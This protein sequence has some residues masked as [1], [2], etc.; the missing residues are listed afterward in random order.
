MFKALESGTTIPYALDAL[1]LLSRSTNRRLLAVGAGRRSSTQA[2]VLGF[3]GEEG[4][5][6]F[7]FLGAD[8]PHEGRPLGLLFEDQTRALGDEPSLLVCVRD[9]KSMVEQQGFQMADTDG[10]SLRAPALQTELRRRL[11]MRQD[12]PPP[13]G[14]ATGEPS[15]HPAHPE[16]SRE[17]SLPGKRVIDAFGRLL[18]LF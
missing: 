13:V 16:V 4:F 8:A 7:V 5:R 1:I 3:A 14:P 2:F 10:P 11:P 18:S 9:A 12:V 6:V 17:I 15:L